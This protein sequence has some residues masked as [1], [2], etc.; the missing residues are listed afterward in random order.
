MKYLIL[1]L[2]SFS[3]FAAPF[4]IDE[5]W[6]PLS[7]PTIM[8]VNFENRLGLLPMEGAV[9]SPQK[10]WSGDYWPMS[11]GNIN[12]RWYAD[13]GFKIPSPNKE[14]ALKLSQDE[15]S[16]LSP[17]EKFDL[18][19]GRYDYPL[20]AE[21]KKLTDY[22]AKGWEGICHG[23]APATMN[24]NEPVAKTVRNPDGI[25][26]PF[27]SADIKAI[28]SYYYAYIYVV[29]NTR[30]IGRRCDSNVMGNVDCKQDLNAGAFHIILTN[31][32]ALQNKGFVADMD[33]F[34]QVWNHPILAYTSRVKSEGGPKRSSAPGTV[35]T[36]KFSTTIEYGDESIN[37]WDPLIGTRQQRTKKQEVNYIVELNSEGVI[38]GGE[39]TSIQRPDFLWTMDAPQSFSPSYARLPELLND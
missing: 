1:L 13:R 11:K 25:S 36:V 33:R 17:A 15:L 29:P 4:S 8:S 10:F 19:N 35:R 16:Q 26:I 23:W 12:Y 7:D 28:I 22:D 20:K 21:V 34:K 9:K 30:Q 31:R 6:G 2:L 14:T 38:I 39:W 27:G 24:H 32:I 5:A 3:T 37:S 18:L